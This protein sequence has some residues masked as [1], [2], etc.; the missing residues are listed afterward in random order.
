MRVPVLVVFSCAGPTCG[1]QRSTSAV[2]YAMTWVSIN[3]LVTCLA[4]LASTIVFMVYLLRFSDQWMYLGRILLAVA[5]G[6][7]SIALLHIL[8]AQELGQV[9]IGSIVVLVSTFLMV[10]GYFGAGLRYPIK[11]VGPFLAPVITV[12]V[13]AVW[14]GARFAV[15]G[16]AAVV[17]VLTPVHIVSNL[18]GL[19]AFFSAFIGSSLY[20]VQDYQLKKR[21][22]L[23]AGGLRLP[24]QTTLEKLTTRSIGIGFPLYTIGIVLGGMWAFQGTQSGI[25]VRYLLGVTSWVIYA[26][27]LQVRLTVG[28]SG[29]RAAVLTIVAFIASLSVA[30]VYLTRSVS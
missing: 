28:W 4:Y 3:I 7:N 2:G 8:F 9:G 10:V 17:S 15:S 18:V 20:I 26:F 27:L 12:V 13:Y 1:C 16:K 6:L 23:R 22:M 14:E 25:A 30:L 19:A 21:K 5:G 24:S 29:R 11:I